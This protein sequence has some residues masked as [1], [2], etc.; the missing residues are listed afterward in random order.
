VMAFSIFT[1]WM[2]LIFLPGFWMM[3]SQHQRRYVFSGILIAAVILPL[4]FLPDIT[5]SL[6]TLANYLQ[7][8]EFS[9]FLFRSFR[10]VTGSGIIARLIC[11]LLFMAIS[12]AVYWRNFLESHPVAILK[13][14]YVIAFTFLVLTPTLHPW[15]A[16][17]LAAFLPFA[18][19][20]AGIVFSW[21]IFLS[22]RVVMAY[23]LTGQWIENSGIP[24]LVVIAPLAAAI[25][26]GVIFYMT[27]RKFDR[28]VKSLQDCVHDK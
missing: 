3:A 27:A 4:P 26:A 28:L 15:Y 24:L 1:K 9:G 20:P 23:G 13:G 18:A 14:G 17:Y 25:M 7:D 11:V 22:Y 8:W 2:P 12:G 19:G 10:A 6:N 21:S 5:N 16:L